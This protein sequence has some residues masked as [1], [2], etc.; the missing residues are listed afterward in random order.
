MKVLRI[1]L[2]AFALLN[3]MTVQAATYFKQNNTTAL[4]STNSWFT[5]GTPPSSGM[6]NIVPGS[7][8]TVTW[9]A[10]VV[11]ANNPALGA[12]L[13]WKGIV[14]ASPGGLV[15]IGTG[16]NNLNIGTSGIDM[17]AASQDL[18]FN[19]NTL[20]VGANQ[21]WNVTSGR[22]LTVS[23]GCNLQLSGGTLGIS[24]NGTV[25]LTNST[26]GGASSRPPYSHYAIGFGG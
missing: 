2:V 22:I 25:I 19:V 7:T 23:G 9:D 24:G 1:G 4:N 11:A 26:S 3:S 17:S 6:T 18:R 14:I 21:I 15:T 16:A 13:N 20:T 12:D 10:C 5:S 8:D